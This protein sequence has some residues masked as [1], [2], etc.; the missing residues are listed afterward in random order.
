MTTVHVDSDEAFPVLIVSDDGYGDTVDIPA[1]LL[2]K[3]RLAEQRL[4]EATNAVLEH[5]RATDQGGERFRH[6]FG[7]DREPE[8]SS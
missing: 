3:F 8:T 6:Y 2:N 7:L 4:D 1:A 5:L